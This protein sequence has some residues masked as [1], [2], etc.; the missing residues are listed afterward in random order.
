[1]SLVFAG[2]HAAFH[3][4]YFKMV[5]MLMHQFEQQVHGLN[6]HTTTYVPRN[7]EFRSDSDNVEEDKENKPSNSAR[8]NKP[9][10]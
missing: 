9:K 5:D 1:M 3:H 2:W 7:Y 8:K 10:E 4:Q 6:L